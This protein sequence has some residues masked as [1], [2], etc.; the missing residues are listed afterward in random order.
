MCEYAG[1]VPDA[2]NY[3]PIMPEDMLTYWAQAYLL[4]TSGSFSYA[5]L[6][7]LLV[8]MQTLQFLIMILCIFEH[9]VKT[10]TSLE[11]MEDESSFLES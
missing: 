7:N 3:M 2:H 9:A 5:M 10:P 11:L 1:I 4:S 6:C 8:D